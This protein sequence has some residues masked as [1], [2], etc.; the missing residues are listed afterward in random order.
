ML[1][2]YLLVFARTG[3]MIMLLP[4]IG[5]HGVPPR[6]RLALALA[7]SFAMTPAVAHAYP[8]TAPAEHDGARP[9]AGRGR[10]PPGSWS[11]PWRASS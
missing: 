8:Q 7:V 9:D 6:V 11:A 10:S 4:A 5:D 3:S 2:I 1:L